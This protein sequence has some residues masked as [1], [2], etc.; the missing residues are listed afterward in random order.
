M[1]RPRTPSTRS[2]ALAACDLRVSISGVSAAVTQPRDRVQLTLE[3]MTCTSCAARIEKKLN[4]LEGV[5]ASV[6][7]ATEQASVAFD[8]ARVQLEQLISTV[9]AAG[10]GAA[11]PRAATDPDRALH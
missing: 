5:E 9:E 2:G 11:L 3:G 4:T 7:Y 6:N 1:I 10:Y 8:P